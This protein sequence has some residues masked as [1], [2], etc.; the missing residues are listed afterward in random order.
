M[1]YLYLTEQG[2]V[3]RKSG[4]RLLVELDQQIVLDVPYTKL[5]HVLL[6]G[7]VQV[8]TQATHELLEKGIDLSYFTRGGQFRGSL[9]PPRSANVQ[10]RLQQ[11]KFWQNEYSGGTKPSFTATERNAIATKAAELSQG[12]FADARTV[13]T[14]LY[15]SGKISAELAAAKDDVEVDIE[16]LDD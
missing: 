14:T 10:D 2:S 11:L 1:A 13:T 4:D 8:T 5:E 6:F 3:L 9:T 15:V 12:Y 7:H 16:F